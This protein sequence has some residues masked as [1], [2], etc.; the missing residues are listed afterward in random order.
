MVMSFFLVNTLTKKKRLRWKVAGMTNVIL[1]DSTLI[2]QRAGGTDK[3]YL[4]KYIS[5]SKYQFQLHMFARIYHFKTH[6]SI[7][8]T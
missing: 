5:D 3:S 4:N 6:L 7:Q 2:V 8:R 1:H